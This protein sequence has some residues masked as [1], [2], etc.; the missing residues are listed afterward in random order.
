MTRSAGP[1]RSELVRGRTRVSERPAL[2]LLRAQEAATAA[3]PN[4]G[5]SRTEK[6]TL[7]GLRRSATRAREPRAAGS[8]RPH[9]PLEPSAPEEEPS[10]AELSRAGI[11]TSLGSPPP[12][13]R[14]CPSAVGRAN[15]ASAPVRNQL[16]KR[17]AVEPLREQNRK[18]PKG[19]RSR[20]EPRGC[21]D[22]GGFGGRGERGGAS[23]RAGRG[24]GARWRPRGEVRAR[25]VPRG[26]GWRSFRSGDS[27]GAVPPGVG[28]AERLARLAG[29][30][31]GWTWCG[32]GVGA[33]PR[34]PVPGA[35]GCRAAS[36]RPPSPARCGQC[37]PGRRG[38]ADRAPCGGQWAS[39]ERERR[40]PR[41]GTWARRRPWVARG[42]AGTRPVSAAP[43]PLS[44]CVTRRR[45]VGGTRCTLSP[46]KKGRLPGVPWWPAG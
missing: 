6:P 25:A 41:A 24:P 5:G 32:R 13:V 30:I 38:R 9:L 3:V 26:A 22:R 11:L 8:A 23:G 1:S 19:P 12:P 44:V 7:A 21:R 36:V 14:K 29:V 2:A 18:W 27:V 39:S 31:S 35:P 16:P 28:K 40:A 37:G 34:E 42:L 15:R 20:P 43:A 33:R 10:E 46:I 4:Q 17:G 45:R